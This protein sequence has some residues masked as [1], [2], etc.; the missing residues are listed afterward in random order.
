VCLSK[1][2]KDASADSLSST[3]SAVAAMVES[4]H[5][6]R[7]AEEVADANELAKVKEVAAAHRLKKREHSTVEEGE[8]EM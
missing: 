2:N 8:E 3:S 6:M 4:S 5:A 1:Y 7:S